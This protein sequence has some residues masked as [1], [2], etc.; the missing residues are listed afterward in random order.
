MPLIT[1]GGDGCVCVWKL[2]AERADAARTKLAAASAASPSIATT[3]T[4]HT[5]PLT[6]GRAVQVDPMKPTSKAPKIKLLKLEL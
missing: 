6:P 5:P 1:G 4:S 3:G 2:P